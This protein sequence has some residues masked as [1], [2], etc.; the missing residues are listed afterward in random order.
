MLIE[1]FLKIDDDANT[2]PQF[3]LLS[4]IIERELRNSDE[5][6]PDTF[7]EVLVEQMRNNEVDNVLPKIEFIV[8]ALDSE[9]SEA[10]AK[11]KGE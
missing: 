8:E 4:S 5:K 7:L 10:L 2:Q 6:H 11:I 9:N 1:F 3:Q